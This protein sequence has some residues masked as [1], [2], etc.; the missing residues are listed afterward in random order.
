VGLFR[1][2]VETIIE[3]GK[4]NA[5]DLLN[6]VVIP[7]TAKA[8]KA[9][10]PTPS[11]WV[12]AGAWAEKTVDGAVIGG[13]TPPRAG[14][15]YAI[16][17]GLPKQG[18]RALAIENDPHTL[19]G[20]SGVIEA[21]YGKGTKTLLAAEKVAVKVGGKRFLTD[22]EYHIHD[23][24]RAGLHYDLAVADLPPGVKEFELHIPRG[25][26]KGRWAFVSTAKG[27]VITPMKDRGVVLAKPAYSLKPSE[28]LDRVRTEPQ[29]WV[30]EHKMDGSLGNCAIRD[31]SATFRSHRDSGQTYYDRLP[32]LEDLRNRS[33]YFLFRSL[34]PGPR[35]NGTVLQGELYHP[36]G[37][38]RMGGILNA[39]PDKAQAIQK[40]RGPARY[41]GW[42]VVMYKGRDVSHLPY[43]ERRALLESITKEIRQYNPFYN[44][45]ERC[46]PGE[47]PVKFYDRI[48]RLSLPF[49]EGVVL[50]KADDPAGSTWFKVKKTDFEDL[51]VD[52]ILPGSG[53]YADTAG[54]LV[55]RNMDN[56]AVGEVGSFAVTDEMRDW[57]W[58]HRELLK[59]SVAK[60]QVQEMTARGAPRAGVFHAFHEGKGSEAGLLMYAESLAGG[61]QE[62]MLRT[63]Y[64]LISA[65]G[66]RR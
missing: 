32:Q 38:G 33:R 35:L 47:D 54:K 66:W 37:A 27:M 60:I 24:E 64:A 7:Q 36:D 57:I 61:N 43:E 29:A 34:F 58:Q 25:A 16:P 30:V 49:G 65:A 15:K 28:F 8:A 52:D 17:K 11:R 9:I 56:G 44:I 10:I 41:Y 63:K 26:F 12:T 5:F 13:I 14:A 18:E 40:L 1:N 62:E 22:M 21:G 53:K 3:W 2:I 50:K 45:V 42:D 23:A 31:F 59:G 39:L 48:T 20:F 51:F 46:K 4:E 55:V 6:S 19:D